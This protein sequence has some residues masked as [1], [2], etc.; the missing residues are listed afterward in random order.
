MLLQL[1]VEGVFAVVNGGSD[2][3]SIGQLV[4]L[5]KREPLAAIHFRGNDPTLWHR[6]RKLGVSPSGPPH[7]GKRRGRI[8]TN[9]RHPYFSCTNSNHAVS[10]VG[11]NLSGD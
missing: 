2:A 10:A 1:D 3:G 8:G 9:H 5:G 11:V 4:L 7:V 6:L